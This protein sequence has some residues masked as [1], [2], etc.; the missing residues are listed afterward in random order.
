LLVREGNPPDVNT[1]WQMTAV[2]I[3]QFTASGIEK[4]CKEDLPASK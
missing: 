1:D 3:R 2:W 4:Q